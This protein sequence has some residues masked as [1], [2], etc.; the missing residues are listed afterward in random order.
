MNENDAQERINTLFGSY[1]A[2]WLDHKVFELF[3]EP[4]YFPELVT[5]R[6]CVLLGGRGTGKTTVLR[7]LSYDGQF[8]LKRNDPERFADQKFFGIFYRVDTNRVTAFKGTERN[9]DQWA[10][11]FGHYLNLVLG[12][13]FVRFLAWH[14]QH[15]PGYATFSSQALNLICTAFQLGGVTNLSELVHAFRLGLVEYEAQI[16]NIAENGPSRLT[17]Q[18]APIDVLIDCA[19]ELT[20]FAD[21]QFYFLI[22]EYENFLDYQQRAVNTLIKHVGTRYT[23]KI[24]VKQLG[25][26]VRHCLNGTEQLI[27]PADYNRISLAQRLEDGVFD[28]F[29]LHVCQAR[30]DQID[31]TLQVRVNTLFPGINDEDE[32]DALIGAGVPFSPQSLALIGTLSS[33]TRQKF[34]GLRKLEQVFLVTWPDNAAPRQ[35]DEAVELLYSNA[36]RY[37]ERYENYKHSLLF[38]LRR[39]KAGIRKYYAGWDVYTK[40]AAG[41]IRFILELVERAFVAHIQK[42]EKWGL[43]LSLK[44]QTQTA[45]AVGRKN[46]DELEGLDVDGAKLTKLVLGLGRIFQ[47]MAADP[48]AHSPE[49]NQFQISGGAPTE[50]ETAKAEKLLGSGVNHVALLR[51]VG[52]K[53]SD[54]GDTKDSDY[55]VHPIFSAFFEFSYRR[56]RKMTL[57]CEQLVLLVDQPKVAINEI[58]QKSGRDETDEPL[59]EQMVLFESFYD[60]SG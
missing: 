20:Q 10:K 40:L 19:R 47:V 31:S 21:R 3:S 27:S 38:S 26:R 35:F 16:N 22:D 48:I 60:S 18:G 50:I 1:R 59:P 43:P 46:L 52:S 54:P 12:G 56:K 49:V 41:N 42:G 29:A 55:T 2:E 5:N 23:I 37:R 17:I 25:W 32:A 15:Y 45:I 36:P 30:L 14:H 6:P 11:L 13:L 58:L 4:N 28:E 33:A 7:C 44:T 57:T 24:G 53:P 34:D 9:D 8:A 39:G 51:L